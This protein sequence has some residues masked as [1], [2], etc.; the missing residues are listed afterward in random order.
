VWCYRVTNRLHLLSDDD[1]QRVR[2]E[3]FQAGE[4]VPDHRA[5]GNRV[6]DFRYPRLHARTEA[7]CENDDRGFPVAHHIESR[8]EAGE[9]QT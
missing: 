4:Q 8:C 2:R 7:S 9:F 3:R 1:D 5:T 6:H